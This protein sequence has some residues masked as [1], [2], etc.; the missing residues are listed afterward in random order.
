[1]KKYKVLLGFS[2]LHEI[3][4]E[5][6]TKEEAEEKVMEGEYDEKN[7]VDVSQDFA[8]EGSEEVK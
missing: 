1:M 4:V 7:V 2:G 3:I 6:E 5:A 8:P